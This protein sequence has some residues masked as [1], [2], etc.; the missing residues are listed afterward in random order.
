MTLEMRLSSR[1]LLCVY[2]V[3][4]LNSSMEKHSR[5]E[6]ARVTATMWKREGGEIESMH[7]KT[8]SNNR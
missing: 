3:L 2:K 7:E 8:V 5:G 1:E 6:R 4:G